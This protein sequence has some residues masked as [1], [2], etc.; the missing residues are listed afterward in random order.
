[1]DMYGDDEND[2]FGRAAR[3][4]A[5]AQAQSLMA[6]AAKGG[7]RFEVWLSPERA[8]WVLERIIAGEFIDPCEAAF[9]AFGEAIELDR[10]PKVRRALLEAMIVAAMEGPTVEAKQAMAEIK[11]KLNERGSC[12]PAVWT[13]E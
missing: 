4:A 11:A 10:H 5:A 8:A 13:P 3:G 7:L 12:E 2:P 9:V 1:M 6:E